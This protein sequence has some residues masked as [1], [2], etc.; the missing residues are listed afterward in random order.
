MLSIKMPLTAR[1]KRLIY[2]N[3]ISAA[4]LLRFLGPGFLGEFDAVVA[5][6]LHRRRRL[7][8]AV[9]IV[10]LQ[11]VAA[12]APLRLTDRRDGRSIP[13]ELDRVLAVLGESAPFAYEEIGVH[14]ARRGRSIRDIS[15]HGN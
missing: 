13:A 10:E 6:R 4:A 15:G 7:L 9:A 5:Q 12:E 2:R 8:R 3:L 1:V 11:L 14:R